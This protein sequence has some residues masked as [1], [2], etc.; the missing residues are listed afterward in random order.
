MN[1]LNSITAAGIVRAHLEAAGIEGAL[2]HRS[3]SVM[4]LAIEKAEAL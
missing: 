2:P 1:R 3:V 4:V